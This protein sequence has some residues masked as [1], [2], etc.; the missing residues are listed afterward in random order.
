MHLAH[1]RGTFKFGQ[2]K[3]CCRRQRQAQVSGQ[4]VIG[5]VERQEVL[6][7]LGG[8]IHEAVQ[9]QVS[10]SCA[11]TAHFAAAQ[12]QAALAGCAHLALHH[13]AQ[14]GACAA[15][16]NVGRGNVTVYAVDAAVARHQLLARCHQLH[17][18]F[19]RVRVVLAALPVSV[20]VGVRQQ[21]A[22]VNFN[23]IR[24]Q[25][26]VVPQFLE[27]CQVTLRRGAQQVGHPVQ[28]HL[29]A[30]CAQ[31]RHRCAGLRHSVAA[32]VLLQNVVIQ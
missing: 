4:L 32:L 24:L 18:R 29:E 22:R 5:C 28:H 19:I 7:A 8:W 20:Q 14:I 25:R 16:N 3:L 11:V 13:L 10:G 27:V 6:R 21:R 1:N 17:Q 31:Q 2:P 30:G 15:G 23:F 9:R 12:A 26:R